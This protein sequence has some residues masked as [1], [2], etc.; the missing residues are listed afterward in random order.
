MGAA[1]R[2]GTLA[3]RIAQA[4]RRDEIPAEVRWKAEAQRWLDASKHLL[5]C[6]C[7]SCRIAADDLLARSL[8]CRQRAFNARRAS[9]AGF[10]SVS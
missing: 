4:E 5:T 8:D 7:P 2:R 6:G 10:E 9:L 3:D 1:K